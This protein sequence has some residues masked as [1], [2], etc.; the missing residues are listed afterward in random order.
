[1]CLHE[2]LCEGVWSESHE[3]GQVCVFGFVTTCMC[4][5]INVCELANYASQRCEQS[6]L[7][8][9]QECQCQGLGSCL[10]Q[11]YPSDLAPD[12]FLPGLSSSSLP[13]HQGSR[14]RGAFSGFLPFGAAALMSVLGGLAVAVLSCWT[15]CCHCQSD[16]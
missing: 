7:A 2:N 9:R 13:S 12:I 8:Q 1:M 4:E 16:N 6:V 11:L 3:S 15:L 10:Q 5:R 14:P